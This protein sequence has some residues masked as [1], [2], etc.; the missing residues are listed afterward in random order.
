MSRLTVPFFVCFSCF[1]WCVHPFSFVVLSRLRLCA[2]VSGY[3]FLICFGFSCILLKSGNG[4]QPKR[5]NDTGTVD[6][7]PLTIVLGCG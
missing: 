2:F 7:G 3:V 5:T 1:A 6:V 4:P